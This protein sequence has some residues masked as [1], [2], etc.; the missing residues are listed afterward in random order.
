MQYVP[1]VGM[2]CIVYLNLCFTFQ[3]GVLHTSSHPDDFLSFSLYLCLEYMCLYAF[4][5]RV[6]FGWMQKWNISFRLRLIYFNGSSLLGHLSWHRI[7]STH[8]EYSFFCK[9][10]Y[11]AKTNKTKSYFA[12]YTSYG[13]RQF[14]P[15]SK[16]K[17]QLPVLKQWTIFSS[18]A[19]RNIQSGDHKY[20]LYRQTKN[21]RNIRFSTFKIISN[22]YSIICAFISQTRFVLFYLKWK[23]SASAFSET[24][25]HW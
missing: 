24:H 11:T 7:Q 2:H 6:S 13:L 8:N 10:K 23:S 19:L 21:A 14:Y 12:V 18:L 16:A 5:Q 1:P 22:H 25:F 9:L 17:H 20:K 4:V 3:F 15:W